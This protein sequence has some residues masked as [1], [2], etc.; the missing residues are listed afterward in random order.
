MDQKIQI[1]KEINDLALSYSRGF[2]TF[3]DYK[4]RRHE[5]L[6]RLENKDNKSLFDQ[7]GIMDVVNTVA[8]MIK[9]S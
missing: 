8:G 4:A 1:I 9:R 5:L 6:V 3:D 7:S 2:I